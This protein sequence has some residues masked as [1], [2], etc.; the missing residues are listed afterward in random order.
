MEYPP[1]PKLVYEPAKFPCG[2]SFTCNADAKPAANT[3]SWYLNNQDVPGVHTKHWYFQGNKSGMNTVKCRA[4]NIVAV[5]EVELKFNLDCDFTLWTIVLINVTCLLFLIIIY[6]SGVYCRKKCLSRSHEK[7]AS[8]E[9]HE[10]IPLNN[11][12]VRQLN[13]PPALSKKVRNTVLEMTRRDDENVQPAAAA[14]SS[15]GYVTSELQSCR[16]RVM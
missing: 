6:V 8:K 13:N 12:A 11:C 5:A 10:C 2:A 3:F 16:N 7:L 15:F 9:V 1:K 4:R 14:A